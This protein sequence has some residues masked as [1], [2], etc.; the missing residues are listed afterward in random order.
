MTDREKVEAIAARIAG[1]FDNPALLKFGALSTSAELDA[2]NIARST[3]EPLRVLVTVNRDQDS[4]AAYADVAYLPE[5][6]T[7]EI[8][9]FDTES[10][11]PFAVEIETPP[12]ANELGGRMHDVALVRQSSDPDADGFDVWRRA[13]NARP[14][15]DGPA[16]EVK[17]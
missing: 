3:A 7:V 6:V 12:G 15:F 17:P 5:G 14:E 2:F 4:G 10:G 8:R 9:N 1:E 13:D 16:P 11:E